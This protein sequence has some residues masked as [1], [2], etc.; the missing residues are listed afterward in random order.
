[1][2]FGSP[3]SGASFNA[4][5][6]SS[7]STVFSAYLGGSL[8][9]SFV[10]AVPIANDA[11]TTGLFWGFDGV[12]FDRLEIS[13][14]TAGFGIDNLSYTSTVPEPGTVGLVATGLIGLLGVTSRRRRREGEVA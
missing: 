10:N 9:S 4:V 12:V 8:V 11:A 3:V 1:M 13:H 14:T 7:T 2:V 5:D 6:N